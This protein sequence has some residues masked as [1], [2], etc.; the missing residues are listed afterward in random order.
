MKF[1]IGVTT[2][3]ASQLQIH[4][5]KLRMPECKPIDNAAVSGAV[6]CIT[7]AKQKI[8]KRVLKKNLYAAGFLCAGV[9]A[10]LFTH[11][12]LKKSQSAVAA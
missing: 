7:Q 10:V 9:G 8:S 2:F 6:T 4:N 3:A 11:F 5:L 12:V 1:I